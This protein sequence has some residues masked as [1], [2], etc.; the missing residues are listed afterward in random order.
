MPAARAA[1]FVDAAAQ[2]LDYLPGEVV[3]KFRDGVTPERQQR[4]LDALRSRPSA[5]ALEWAGEVAILRDA[6]AARRARPRRA[7]RVPARSALRR[8]ELPPPQGPRRRTTP[9]TVRASGTCRR[10][11]CRRA[12]DINPGANQTLIVAIVDTGVTT[13]NTTQDGGDVERDGDPD[14]HRRLRDQSGSRGEPP[15]EPDGLRDQPGH[16]GAGLG[17]PRHARELDRR[18]GHQQRA[19]RR[20]DRLQRADHAGEGVHELVGRAVRVLRRRRARLRAAGRRRLPDDRGRPGHPLCGRQRREGD[21]PESRRQ[22]PVDDRAGR[23]QLRGR[24]RARSSRWPAGNEKE[25][26]NPTHYPALYAT[27]IEGAMAVGATNRS[28][29]RAYYSNTGS[30][31]EIAAPG[32]DSRDSDAAAAASSGSRRSVRRSAI[33]RP[34]SSRG[35]MRYAEVGYSGTSMATPHVAGLAA[36]LSTQGIKTPAAIEQLIKKTAKFLGTPSAAERQPQRRVRFRP[37][38]ATRRPVRVR[39]PEVGLMRPMLRLVCVAAALVAR[40]AGAAARPGQSRAAAR[41]RR[42]SACAPTPSSISTRCARRRASTPCSA[43]RSSPPSAAASRWWTSGSTSSR[44]SRSRARARPGSRVF[45]SGGEVFPL[46]IPLTVTMTPIE[47]GGG[48][49]FASTAGGRLTPYAGAAF[50]SMGYTE[51]S[52]FADA[53]G[54]HVRAVHGAGPC[55]AASTS[56]SCKWIAAVRARSQYRR[57]PNALGAGGVSKDFGESDLG[58]FTARVTIGIRTKR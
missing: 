11:T 41:R 45:V 32:G 36:L 8:A 23:D 37:H 5:D 38:S 39:H 10:S 35:S 24:A 26:G 29:N 4:A 1:A 47:A 49:R 31:I 34:S 12:W 28:G 18:R 2:G 44:A 7:A 15:G 16:D 27:A 58:G 6:V 25:D 19:A 52:D 57:V 17:R 48:W 14:D 33:R 13:A 50:L 9:A 46:G 54:E 56:A 43:R 42:R 51:T 3:V 22:Q 20:G 40:A 55:S 21:Q 53:G 30:Y